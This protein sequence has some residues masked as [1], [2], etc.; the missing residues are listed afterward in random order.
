M[1]PQVDLSGL[2]DVDLPDIDLATRPDVTRRKRSAIP[3]SVIERDAE[4]GQL[5]AQAA[6]AASAQWARA[7]GV[8]IPTH[9]DEWKAVKKRVDAHPEQF[10]AADGAYA[11]ALYDGFEQ[12]SARWNAEKG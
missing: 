3:L 2:S 11:Q 10:R 6:D 8:R 4:L 9:L 12:A 1:W 7:S 5:L